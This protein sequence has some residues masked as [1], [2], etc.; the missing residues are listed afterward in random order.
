MEDHHNTA[1]FMAGNPI[2]GFGSVHFVRIEGES[3]WL[4]LCS[5]I[6]YLSATTPPQ[7]FY[8]I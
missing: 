2:K 3:A 4:M 7:I 5:K 6:A 1:H 8:T